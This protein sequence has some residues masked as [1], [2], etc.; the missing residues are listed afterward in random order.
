MEEILPN[1]R[2]ILEENEERKAQLCDL[3]FLCTNGQIFHSFRL[4]FASISTFFKD[5]LEDEESDV[6]TLPEDTSY[7]C[8]KAFHQCLLS[9][10]NEEELRANFQFF[11]LFQI[12]LKTEETLKEVLT[13]A[14]CDKEYVSE[15]NYRKH[16]KLHQREFEKTQVD[17]QSSKVV[18][19]K[20][21]VQKPKRYED[22]ENAI[23]EYY[24]DEVN[25]E[26]QRKRKKTAFKCDTCE[27]YFSSKQCLD[28]HG[29]IHSNDRPFSCEKCGKSFTTLATLQT[30]K[31]LHSGELS[32]K[33]ALKCPHCDKSLNNASN[34]NRHIRSVH[35]ELSD[36]KLHECQECGKVFKDP[37]ALKAH[38]KIHTGLRPFSCNYCGKPFL[39][40]GQ[41]RVHLRIHTGE[42]P[43]ACDKC[44]KK[45]VTKDNLKSHQLHKHI[46]VTYARNQLCSI[47]GMAFIKPFDLKVHLLKHSGK[48][49]S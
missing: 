31:K 36:K 15:A 13:C 37:S 18:S 23:S 6:I 39:T 27:K 12:K 17:N 14:E 8:I 41:M 1:L 38:A 20:R 47:C 9:N 30:H 2:E 44:D 10:L 25:A 7:E 49:I 26:L 29:K 40:A 28:N 33:Y 16:M 48:A 19:K 46:G 42:R 24:E 43:Y 4:I 11:Q 5:I 32:E 35:F 3:K 34:L 22:E 45:F 21:K